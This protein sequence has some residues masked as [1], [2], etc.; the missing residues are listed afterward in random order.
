M[1]THRIRDIKQILYIVPLITWVIGDY[2]SLQ[3][4]SLVMSYIHNINGVFTSRLGNIGT[5]LDFAI[6]PKRADLDNI[7]YLLQ[8]GADPNSSRGYPLRFAASR[9]FFDIVCLLVAYGADVNFRV[10]YHFSAVALAL[11]LDD[12]SVARFLI[13]NG[14]HT[15]DFFSVKNSYVYDRLIKE[16]RNKRKGKIN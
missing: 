12:T 4:T 14:A 15:T 8:H 5:L 11:R 9:G 13:Q 10:G 1:H 7:T 6:A 3:V 16:E 2:S